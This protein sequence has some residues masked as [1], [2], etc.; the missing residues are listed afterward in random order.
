MAITVKEA[1]TLY[2][3]YFGRPADFVG[4]QY[5]TGTET[6]VGS[7]EQLAHS[8]Y[9][10]AEGKKYFPVDPATNQIDVTASINAIYANMF[11]RVPDTAG[12]DYWYNEIASGK[13]NLAEAAVAIYKGAQGKDALMI[14]NKIAAATQFTDQ[15]AASNQ[16]SLYYGEQAFA[17]ANEFLNTV[18]DVTDVT[19]AGF[20][21][22][23]NAAVNV[24]EAAG[25]GAVTGEGDTF[26]LDV[27]AARFSD[28]G[29]LTNEVNV[30]FKPEGKYLTAGNDVIELYEW[31]GTKDVIISDIFSNDN[32]KV[33]VLAERL[34]PVAT[35]TGAL[36]LT[37]VENLEIISSVPSNVSLNGANFKGLEAIKLIG[38]DTTLDVFDFTYG[39]KIDATENA[40]SIIGGKKADTINGGNGSD[41]INAGSGNDVLT[42]G[43]GADTFIVGSVQSLGI[44]K[45][46][47]FSADDKISVEG[48][49]PKDLKKF[50]ASTFST[51]NYKSLDAALATFAAGGKYQTNAGDAVIFSYDGK[52]YALLA[53]GPFIEARDAL[54]DITG[55]NVASLTES[56]FGTNGNLENYAAFKA[57]VDAGKVTSASPTTIKSITAIDAAALLTT[58]AAY[59]DKI[60]IGG[61]GAVTD[62]PVTVNMN[63]ITLD[64][65]T[66]ASKLA[67][68]AMVSAI[69]ITGTANADTITSSF[70][71]TINGGAGDDTITI[72]AVATING[73]S[74]NDTINAPAG[75]SINGNAGD[76]TINVSAAATINGGSGDD[77]I[78]ASAATD[79]VSIDGGSGT[80]SIIG[81]AGNDTI[82]GGADNDTIIGGAGDDSI[83]GGEG[84]D[85]ITGGSGDDKI[86]LTETTPA[87]DT[88]VFAATAAA[89]GVD[90]ITGFT[91][92]SASG[93]DVLNFTATGVTKGTSA[94]IGGSGDLSSGSGIGVITGV[95]D[96]SEIKFTSSA[97]S[98]AKDVN[99][100][101]VG[102]YIIITDKDGDSKAGNIYL[103]TTNKENATDTTNDMTI[104]LLG[105][106]MRA[107]ESTAWHGDNFAS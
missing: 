17:K 5:W 42:G 95:A 7:L 9:N 92:G 62:G 12:F 50:D 26:K 1:Q 81:G 83:T 66:F 39:V 99:L 48:F 38:D 20:A 80:D 30:G 58:D 16:P 86:I 32:D 102:Q 79:A 104:E 97:A 15:V 71:G 45:I 75:G 73:G 82:N 74:G 106:V 94:V 91:A 21:A 55:A 6:L 43:N 90:T 63:A 36:K 61:I 40:D 13:I 3:S 51:V 88:I 53:N 35:G 98:S 4:L 54:V 41:T 29:T 52:T 27:D 47:D 37:A 103:I 69:N 67:N 56:N 87:S 22:Q 33:S 14:E 46:L 76:N 107:N 8:F 31:D 78:D 68:V 34:S 100:A 23:V 11:A 89:N 24:A 25:A 64:T 18:T 77:T 84:A 49:A 93:K 105:T 60:A 72:S 70:G 44:D 59:L 19:S 101:D 57:A 85:S 96:I 65:A 10:S 2:V 28:G